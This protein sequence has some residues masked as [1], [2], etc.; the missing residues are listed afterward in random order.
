MTKKYTIEGWNQPD[1]PGHGWAKCSNAK[2]E[3]FFVFAADGSRIPREFI[4]FGAAAAY[5]ESL[6]WHKC[7]L[8]GE[9][10]R[11]FGNNAW[12]LSKGRCCDTCNQIEVIPHR[13]AQMLGGR[14]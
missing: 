8:C 3:K 2:A 1:G 13:M 6:D 9:Q 10:Y 7:S 4:T 12:P 5:V 11:G 14:R